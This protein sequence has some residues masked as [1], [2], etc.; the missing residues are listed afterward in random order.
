MDG[1]KGTEILAGD[2]SVTG[3]EPQPIRHSRGQGLTVASPVGGAL[4]FKA[5]GHQT[6]GML[7]VLES[8]PAPGEG[9][10]LHLHVNEDEVVY[11][12]EGTLRLRLGDETELAAAGTFAYIPRGLPHTWQNVGEAPARF[13]AIFTPAAPGMES[14]FERFAELPDGIAL[15]DAFRALGGAAGMRVLGPPLGE[16]QVA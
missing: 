14:F 7:T 5:L 11:V 4:T 12:L 10:P 1:A 2:P 8:T 3:D 9:P 6:R 15:T 13:L 16:S